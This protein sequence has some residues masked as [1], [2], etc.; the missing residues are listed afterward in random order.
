MPI[1]HAYHSGT[2]TRDFVKSSRL[3]AHQKSVLESSFAIN[4]YPN[5]TMIKELAQKTKLKERRV[6]NWFFKNRK[7]IK[8]ENSE[9]SL[10]SCEYIR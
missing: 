7:K 1:N 4:C 3:T 8:L 9:G 10:S 6:Y 2:G 5:E